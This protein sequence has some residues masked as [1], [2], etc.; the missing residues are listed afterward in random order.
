[1]TDSATEWV[2]LVAPLDGAVE[3]LT[4]FGEFFLNL[5]NSFARPDRYRFSTLV[6]A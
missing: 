3:F 6:D 4:H 2:K 1:M 5:W